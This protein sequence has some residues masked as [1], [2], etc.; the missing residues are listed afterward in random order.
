MSTYL[1]CNGKE[2]RD[3]AKYSIS[4]GSISVKDVLEFPV[5]TL[6]AEQLTSATVRLSSLQ[7]QLT[8]LE[9]LQKQTE[10]NAR[11]ILDSYLPSTP[12]ENTITH[13]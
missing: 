6:T 9:S 5:P 7:T 1:Y 8:A 11:F 3:K 13:A 4:L 10:D 2:I 12:V